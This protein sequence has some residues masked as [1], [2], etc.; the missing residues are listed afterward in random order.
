MDGHIALHRKLLKNPVVCK[1]AD[2]LAVWIWLLLNAAWKEH[3]VMWDG[4]RITLKPGQLPP[5]G[6]K[7]ISSELQISESKVQ[8]ILKTFEN[9]QQIEQQMSN[10]NRLITILSWDKYQVVE[11]QSGQQVNSQRTASE[12][13]V[14]TTEE[15]NN[16]GNKGN[17]GK[18]GNISTVQIDAEFDELWS[19]YPKKQGKA[20][21]R[22]KYEKAR[23]EGTT[24]EEVRAGI[25]AYKEYLRL[26]DKDDQYVKMGSTFFNQRSW[27]DDWTA[28]RSKSKNPFTEMLRNGDY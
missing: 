11:Q 23:K 21:A 25:V 28:G 26:S 6:R 4:K 5:T 16:K 27:Q 1:D 13:Q 9:E 8:R 10:R 19:M 7:R 22:K 3:D 12:Q 17:K 24:F 15:R 18:K 14:N 2:H 20:D